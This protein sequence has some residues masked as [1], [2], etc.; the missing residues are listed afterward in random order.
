MTCVL[1][2]GEFFNATAKEESKEL[3]LIDPTKPQKRSSQKQRFGPITPIPNPN[4]TKQSKEKS[5]MDI[6][7][8][9]TQNIMENGIDY[10]KKRYNY[11][12]YITKKIAE[13]M[14]LESENMNLPENIIELK[15]GFIQE[16]KPELFFMGE[17][18][19][20]S[21]DEQLENR[22][23]QAMQNWERNNPVPKM[24]KLIDE[25]IKEKWKRANN[26]ELQMPYIKEAQEEIKRT[27]DS[28]PIRNGIQSDGSGLG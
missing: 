9:E 15:E 12:V 3:I 25:N 6:K 26:G 11:Q 4:L 20:F 1:G 13:E 7:Q 19:I 23:K 10:V 16:G 2:S 17:K 21:K 14:Q 24:I 22:V 5:I 28:R 8:R 27:K 18:T